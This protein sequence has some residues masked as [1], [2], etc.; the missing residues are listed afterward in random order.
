MDFEEE[1]NKIL[2][3]IE[4]SS[5]GSYQEVESQR[6]LAIDKVFERF[7][8]YDKNIENKEEAL[9][10]L[11]NYQYLYIDDLN[12][13]DFVRYFNSK[14]FY[15]MKLCLGGIVVNNN[16]ENKG[17]VL[18]KSPTK[19]YLVVKSKIFFKKLKKDDL[20]KMRLMDMVNNIE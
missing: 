10:E 13:G 14:I 9:E 16:Y 15:N 3:N 1:I 19:K 7:M 18:I 8:H 6:N 5:Y 17:L 12:P 4:Y 11:E 2:D 20:V